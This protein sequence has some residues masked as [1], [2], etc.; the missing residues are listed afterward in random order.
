MI[1]MKNSFHRNLHLYRKLQQ[2]FTTS[3]LQ[4]RRKTTPV[5]LPIHNKRLH[6]QEKKT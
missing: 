5:Y 3:V 2:K 6:I 4:I 1:T